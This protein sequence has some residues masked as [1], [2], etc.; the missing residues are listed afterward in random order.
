VALSDDEV[1][2]VRQLAETIRHHRGQT[3]K[4]MDY[5]DLLGNDITLAEAIAGDVTH[6]FTA[7]I[8]HFNALYSSLRTD[9]HDIKIRRGPSV[10][11]TGGRKLRGLTIFVRH[12]LRPDEE[13]RLIVVDV[14]EPLATNSNP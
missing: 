7:S 13:T 9:F 1:L 6:V 4:D 12:P 2:A 3:S 14:F 10:M 5:H 8:S 11:V